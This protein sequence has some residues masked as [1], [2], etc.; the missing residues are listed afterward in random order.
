MPA[1]LFEEIQEGVSME[2]RWGETRVVGERS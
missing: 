1:K 2:L